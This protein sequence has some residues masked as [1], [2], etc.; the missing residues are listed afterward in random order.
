MQVLEQAR[1]EHGVVL[2]AHV[3]LQHG[4]QVQEVELGREE[5]PATKTTQS[6]F[7]VSAGGPKQRTTARAVF[8][9]G[10]E[11]ARAAMSRAGWVGGSRWE[12]TDAVARREIDPTR[13]AGSRIRGGWSATRKDEGGGKQQ[14]GRGA[15]AV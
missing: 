4:I 15:G 12:G 9:D 11:A 14:P 10:R 13:Q 6:E 3:M 5:R 8:D 7:D 2:C 1:P